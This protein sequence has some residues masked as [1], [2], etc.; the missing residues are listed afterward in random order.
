MKSLKRV[1]TLILLGSLVLSLN[2]CSKSVNIFRWA[3]KGGTSTAKES[4][5]ADGQSA[6][7]SK[8]YSDALTY[9]NKILEQDPSNSQ[10]LY[11]KAQ[12]L[13][14]LG[15]LNLADLI[16][17]VIKEAQSESTSGVIANSEL[18]AFF[19]RGK[20]VSSADDLIPKSV[21][22]TKLYKT[23][24]DVVPVLKQIAD[25]G[26]DGIIPADDPDVNINLAFFM[27][28]RAACRFL[29]SDADGIPG[30]D[31]GDV[32]NVK[33]DFSMTVPDITDLTLAQKQ[34]LRDQM[35]NGINDAFG[36]APTT[37]GAINY[38]EKAI[39]KIGSKQ[40]S[41][42]QD[43]KENIADLKS[44]IKNEIDNSLNPKLIDAGVAVIDWH[45]R[46]SLL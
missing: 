18:G 16:S 30:D 21:N 37:N 17:N 33:S 29:D 8:D 23:A 20:Y 4:L 1:L 32:I 41:S 2:G 11:G 26:T 24:N 27:L 22:L 9:Y 6:L 31:S 12:A 19:S 15:G 38:L 39:K 42:I 46:P 25:G 5:L 44:D 45:P 43:L 34:T 28:V 40:G 13:V 14:G 35:Q 3:H 36:I 10:A 7:G